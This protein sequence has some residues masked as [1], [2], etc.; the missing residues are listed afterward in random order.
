MNKSKLSK[1]PK[2]KKYA[3]KTHPEIFIVRVCHGPNV[4]R[5]ADTPEAQALLLA[6]KIYDFGL[7][8]VSEVWETFTQ[9]FKREPVELS[10][11]AI[12]SHMPSDLHSS[13]LKRVAEFV[14]HI[15]GM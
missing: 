6:G 9:C 2:A 14:S 4:S 5:L 13:Y 12:L 1:V 7:P 11:E 10:I 8:Y 3:E 15:R